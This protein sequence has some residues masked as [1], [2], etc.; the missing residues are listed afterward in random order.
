MDKKV[1][2]RDLEEIDRLIGNEVDGALKHFRAGDFEGKVRRRIAAGERPG[3]RPFLVKIAVPAA[4]ALLLAAAAALVFF[5]TLR[6][7]APAPVDAGLFADVL[8]QFPSF[9]RSEVGPPPGL[10]GKERISE[11]LSGFED[12]F[13]SVKRRREEEE[14]R[15][16]VHAG[17]PATPAISMKDRMRILFKDKVIERALMLL[18]V[19]S[20]EA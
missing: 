11:T 20:K 7:P 3:G 1:D 5:A 16:S 18:S 17:K 9:S 8:G 15:I 10:G 19:K 6:S 2:D 12:A 13:V 4:A 14:L